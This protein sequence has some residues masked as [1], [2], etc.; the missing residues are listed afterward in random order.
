MLLA[1]RHGDQAWLAAADREN[2]GTKRSKYREE[3]IE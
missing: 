2:Q 3:E 1:S